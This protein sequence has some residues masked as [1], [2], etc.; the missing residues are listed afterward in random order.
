[1]GRQVLRGTWN[2]HRKSDTNLA[3]STRTFSQILHCTM[4]TLPAIWCPRNKKNFYFRKGLEFVSAL[5][6]I[7]LRKI[8]KFKDC[9]N[10]NKISPSFLIL[11]LCIF[12]RLSFHC[13]LEKIAIWKGGLID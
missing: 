4:G 13:A 9:L 12:G 8:E 2:Y 3:T 6:Y 1:M 7:L 11:E 5:V 10:G